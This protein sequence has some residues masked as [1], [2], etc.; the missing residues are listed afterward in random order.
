MG[1]KLPHALTVADARAHVAGQGVR[2]PCWHAEAISA[3]AREINFGG[4]WQLVTRDACKATWREVFVL[5]GIDVLD[6]RGTTSPRSMAHLGRRAR[7]SGP[8]RQA[9]PTVQADMT[10]LRPSAPRPRTEKSLC[11]VPLYAPRLAA[12]QGEQP[13]LLVITSW[14]NAP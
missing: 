4:A 7:R 6:D 5:S 14:R 3:G 11:G 9:E 13:S 2:C 12:R 10:L 1:R 8:R